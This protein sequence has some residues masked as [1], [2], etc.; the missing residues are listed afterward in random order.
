[1]WHPQFVTAPLFWAWFAVF[2]VL[3]VLARAYAA[4]HYKAGSNELDV[5]GRYCL[6][7]ER[8]PV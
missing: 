7:P 2:V 8:G 4:R 6:E 5:I 3:S 1:M